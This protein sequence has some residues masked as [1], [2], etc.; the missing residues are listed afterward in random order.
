MKR[1]RRAVHWAP[2]TPVAAPAADRDDSA[3]ADGSNEDDSAVADGSNADA[4]SAIS[5]STVVGDSLYSA[6]EADDRA[7]EGDGVPA[8]QTVH[9]RGAVFIRHDRPAARI[10]RQDVEHVGNIGAGCLGIGGSAPT[11][12]TC[13][14]TSSRS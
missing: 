1:N 3:V 10:D 7:D 12:Q 9:R 4:M 2:V 13:D 11:P 6:D 14:R 8:L 5:G